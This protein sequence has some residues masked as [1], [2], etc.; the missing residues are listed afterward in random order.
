V[1]SIGLGGRDQFRA[2]FGPEGALLGTLVSGKIKRNEF[3]L[4][5]DV[6]ANEAEAN[7]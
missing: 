6:L 1:L 2:D 3:S 4:F 5:A 7:P